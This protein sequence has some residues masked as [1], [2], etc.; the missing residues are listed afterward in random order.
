MFTHLLTHSLRAF[1]FEDEIPIENTQFT[2][3][4]N[5]RIGVGSFG[6]VYK[7][8]LN[9]G[10]HVAVKLLPGLDDPSFRKE[11]GIMR[12]V[13]GL[14]NVIY[15]HGYS[16]VINERSYVAILT[17]HCPKSLKD[18]IADPDNG[19]D[20]HLL[21]KWM[22]YCYQIANG[23]HS[24]SV[25]GVMH[26]DLKA[27]NC[28]ITHD[29][30]IVIC[31]FG[32]A[33]STSSFRQMSKGTAL[34]TSQRGT[35]GYIAKE[36]FEGMISE[37]S[38]VFAYGILVVYLLFCEYPW[39]D[40]RGTNLRDEVIVDMITRGKAPENVQRLTDE[41]FPELKPEALR[42]F[43][44][45]CSEDP[46]SRP[47]FLQIMNIL[48]D[49]F[50]GVPSAPALTVVSIAPRKD[51]RFLCYYKYYDGHFLNG[52]STCRKNSLAIPSPFKVGVVEVCMSFPKMDDSL[53][54]SLVDYHIKIDQKCFYSPQGD[55]GDTWSSVRH[56]A[57]NK[58]RYEVVDNLV[59][60][61]FG[62]QCGARLTVSAGFGF[63][64]SQLLKEF[65]CE[66]EVPHGNVSVCF[67]P[68]NAVSD[69]K[70][71]Y[72][73]L[74]YS[75]SSFWQEEEKKVL[76][77]NTHTFH[78]SAP[79]SELIAAMLGP[80]ST[81]DPNYFRLYI[82][83]KPVTG[84]VVGDVDLSVITWLCNN[85]TNYG[86][87]EPGCIRLQR[88]PTINAIPCCVMVSPRW[89]F[90]IWID[91]DP[92]NVCG[93]ILSQ[94]HARFPRF[95]ISKRIRLEIPEV[96]TPG[97]T[98]VCRP[99]E[100]NPLL[101]FRIVTNTGIYPV[102]A[103]EN[104]LARQVLPAE[105]L[106][107]GYDHYP[108]EVCGRCCIGHDQ[109]IADIGITWDRCVYGLLGTE[110]DDERGKRIGLM[111]DGGTF[112]FPLSKSYS[113]TDTNVYVEYEM[114]NKRT[115]HLSANL[116]TDTVYFI[117]WL[118]AMKYKSIAGNNSYTC[119]LRVRGM[120][121]RSSRSQFGNCNDL[122]LVAY[123]KGSYDLWLHI[124]DKYSGGHR[125]IW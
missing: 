96:H 104:S 102:A 4:W 93:S 51:T 7:G 75:Y 81:E 86:G 119:E 30:N 78:S 107:A 105:L 32:L 95:N 124:D 18:A 10:R 117:K 68:F 67:P 100:D 46:Y 15:Y 58:E 90:G 52:P 26:R 109:T 20:P 65:T 64:Q 121:T 34:V 72:S 25:L 21:A 98:I 36:A 106:Q 79:I 84:S 66:V 48:R 1:E 73:K 14:P 85:G 89:E 76:D 12:R 8:R 9:S 39:K 120:R 118:V 3:D 113:K 54:S 33:V 103:H 42:I 27:E 69:D 91:A 13:N 29:D 71:V 97:M 59:I 49:P 19:N 41:F 112:A 2:I 60:F 115:I 50:K 28:L 17:E 88:T 87:H 53:D 37:F 111:L 43:A 11:I 74:V 24:L 5:Q 123:Y 62:A 47:K 63:D 35:V 99:K 83:N 116:E 92:F 45:C 94:M 44:A 38:D 108:S 57:R 122:D 6:E 70:L 110:D 23:M 125:I 77:A 114:W 61:K 56:T 55:D 22:K 16:N 101:D 31:D 80:S 82:K 40:A